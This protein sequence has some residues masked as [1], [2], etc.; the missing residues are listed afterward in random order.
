MQEVSVRTV[1]FIVAVA[2]PLLALLIVTVGRAALTG[3]EATM[4]RRTQ[5]NIWI[6]AL[7]GPANLGLWYLLN[8]LLAGV[9]SR[10]VIGYVLAALVFVLGGFATGF[11]S[12]L[13]G[14]RR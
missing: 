5:R 3:E 11:F 4:N 13:R 7:A 9:G 6:L 14:E 12:R 2:T 8:G 1:M 10:S